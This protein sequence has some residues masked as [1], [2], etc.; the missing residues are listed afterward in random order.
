MP[1]QRVLENLNAWASAW[2]SQEVDPYL[3]FYSS[4]FRPPEGTSRIAWR[5][6]RRVRILRPTRIEL[7]IREIRVEPLNETRLRVVFEQT[8]RSES[9]QDI[10]TKIQE[11]VLEG[12]EWKIAKE[13]SAG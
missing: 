2:A 3:G 7:E 10:V 11:W 8:Y 9:F 6:D 13:E 12:E 1:E 4:F 5:R